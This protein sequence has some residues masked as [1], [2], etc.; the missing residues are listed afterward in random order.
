MD[1][2]FSEKSLAEIKIPVQL[3]SAEKDQELDNRYN[4]QYFAKLLPNTTPIQVVKGAG[5]FV[6]MALQ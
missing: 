5:H 4:V 6:F 2:F 3:F 1:H